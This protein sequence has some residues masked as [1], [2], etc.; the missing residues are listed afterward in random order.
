MFKRNMNANVLAS[1]FK[2]TNQKISV[3]K[4]DAG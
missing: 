4:T 2:N 1:M 3:G